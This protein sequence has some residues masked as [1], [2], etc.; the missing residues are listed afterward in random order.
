MLHSLSRVQLLT[1]RLGSLEEAWSFFSDPCNLAAI[2]PPW[3]AFTVTCDPE[4]MYAGQIITY[5]IAP[6]PGLPGLA[7]L[8]ASWVTEITHVRGPGDVGPD[9]P[10]FFVDEQRLGPY[11]FWHHQHRFTVE[12]HGVRME[13][14]VRYALPYGPLGDLAHRL[15]VRRRLEEIFDYRRATLAK[16][17]G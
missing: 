12:G 14:E 10:L 7:R 1:G 17:M 3:L 2:T 4:P 9:A 13:D 5:T 15:M 16:L 11:R 6:F 8:R